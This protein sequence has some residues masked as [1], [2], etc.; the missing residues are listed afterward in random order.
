MVE[1]RPE[2]AVPELS[3]HSCSGHTKFLENPDPW[4]VEAMLL[5]VTE[6]WF[7]GS[8]PQGNA[9]TNSIK[10]KVL[11]TGFSVLIKNLFIFKEISRAQFEKNSSVLF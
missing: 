9:S 2:Y 11:C 10:Q 1:P 4:R 3:C 6:S 7:S 8:Q 5:D